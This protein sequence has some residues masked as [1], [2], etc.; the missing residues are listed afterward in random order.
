MS[1]NWNLD[2]FLVGMQHNTAIWK[3]VWQYGQ[4]LKQSYAKSQQFHNKM[5]TQEN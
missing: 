4:K 1:R 3:A 2:T 5:Y